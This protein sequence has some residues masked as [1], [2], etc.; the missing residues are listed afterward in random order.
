MEE[1]KL[2]K[3]I[4][5]IIGPHTLFPIVF[6]ILITQAQLNLNQLRILVPSILILEVILPLGYISFAP[7]FGLAGKWD[8]EKRKERIPLFAL[9]L[10]TT[11]LSLAI[12]H[13]YGTQLLFNITLIFLILL[14]IMA[15]IT[16]FWKIS[17]HAALVTA[18]TIFI[19]F[20]YGWRL[21][22]LY[23]LIPLTGW[24]RLKLK[25][26]TPAQVVAGVLVPT[27]YL[28]LVLVIFS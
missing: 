7:R 2:A 28:F 23:L 20:L 14:A 17:L 11:G 24:A 4:S 12:I 18:A 10:T 5:I 16:E 25:K 19:N 22:Y 1:K 6:G 15:A 8:M 13:F 26:H 3:W 21:S 9:V 27:I